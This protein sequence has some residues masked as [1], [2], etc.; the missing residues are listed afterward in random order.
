MNL[1]S[2][3]K[4]HQGRL[5]TPPEPLTALSNYKLDQTI[6]FWLP[7]NFSLVCK[8]L[9]QNCGE[10]DTVCVSARTNDKV[11]GV[12]WPVVIASIPPCPSPSPSRLPPSQLAASLPVPL[13]LPNLRRWLM[14]IVNPGHVSR[15]C[16]TRNNGCRNCGYTR[17]SF[18]HFV[19][20]GR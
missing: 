3:I 6:K 2:F 5:L 10:K 7:G 11:S 4:F 16:P 9:H 17:L 15:D 14:L 18:S 8:Y 13:V 20:G 19:F 12:V 1:S